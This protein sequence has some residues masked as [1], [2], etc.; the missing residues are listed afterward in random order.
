MNDLFKATILEDNSFLCFLCCY[1]YVVCN[2]QQFSSSFFAFLAISL[3]CTAVISL[4][5]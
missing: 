5:H 1:F 3:Q 2:M 4:S